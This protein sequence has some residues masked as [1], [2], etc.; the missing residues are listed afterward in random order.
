MKVKS[1]SKTKSEKAPAIDLGALQHED[2]LAGIAL[3][4]AEEALKRAMET[5]LS[6]HARVQ[7]SKSNLRFASQAVITN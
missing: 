5:H 1:M 7:T 2:R 4:K 3:K 6:A